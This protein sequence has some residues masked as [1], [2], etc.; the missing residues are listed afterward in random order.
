MG[1]TNIFWGVKSVGGVG[2]TIL[3]PSSAYC[4]QTWEHQPPET[5]RNCSGL[6]RDCLIPTGEDKMTGGHYVQ[7]SVMQ[8]SHSL[9]ELKYNILVFDI[10]CTV[11]RIAMC[12]Q[13]DQPDA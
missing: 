6:Y 13:V 5:L 11:R 10:V 12:I 9:S 2:M 3:P 1:A 8:H 4:L 7:P